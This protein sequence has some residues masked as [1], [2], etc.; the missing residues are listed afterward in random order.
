MHRNRRGTIY[1]MPMKPHVDRGNE[2]R[3]QFQRLGIVIENL[4]SALYFQV[5]IHVYTRVYR[6]FFKTK[7]LLEV[8]FYF[9]KENNS[10][11]IHA[12][13]YR[14]IY[15][16]IDACIKVMD[17]DWAAKTQVILSHLRMQ[18]SD[19]PFRSDKQYLSSHSLEQRSL[20][21]LRLVLNDV[22]F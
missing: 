6:S 19:V 1:C 2:Q 3:A 22:Q 12:S 10:H 14:E 9:I 18:N 13:V 17:V 15:V 8:C 7:Q 4:S 21:S 11:T 5:C 20:N 16:Y